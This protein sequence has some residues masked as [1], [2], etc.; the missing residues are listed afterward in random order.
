M[1]IGGGFAVLTLVATILGLFASETTPT[2]MR[3]S[4]LD[5]FNYVSLVSLYDI[6][7][8]VDGNF[9]FIWKF[10]ILGIVAVI[11]FALGIV[12]FKK[13]DLPL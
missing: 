6:S 2:M 8:I 1:A 3:M 10:A 13:K 11:C 4:A 12:V 7:A 9:A 5:P